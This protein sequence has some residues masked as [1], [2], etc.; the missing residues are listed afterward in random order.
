MEVETRPQPGE[1][2]AASL[3]I[4]LALAHFLLQPAR[5]QGAYGG[6]FLGSE[7]ASLLEEIGFNFQSDIRF[8]AFH[9]CTH[10][11]VAR[12]YVLHSEDSTLSFGP[13]RT[14]IY[15]GA[16]TPSG[17][18]GQAHKYRSARSSPQAF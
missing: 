12:F 10:F 15:P 8:C 18:P 4:A 3:V 1:G 2:T 7:N 11:R 5:E 9:E 13:W 17:A 16:S 6:A 14:P